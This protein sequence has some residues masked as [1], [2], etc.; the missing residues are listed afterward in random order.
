MQVALQRGTLEGL[1]V[2]GTPAMLRVKCPS[3]HIMAVKDKHIGR[4]VKCPQ[5][6][7]AMRVKP[8][9]EPDEDTTDEGRIWLCPAG[10]HFKVLPQHSGKAVKCPRCEQPVRIPE[11]PP[12]AIVADEQTL[13][14]ESSLTTPQDGTTNPYTANEEG[15]LHTAAKPVVARSPQEKL[16]PVL[17][18]LGSAVSALIGIAL[19]MGKSGTN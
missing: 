9:R 8:P 5:C 19:Y 13:D 14:I 18:L 6:F 15:V 7:I 3:G 1:V 11:F 16:W 12:T 2:P 10:H 4:K 17:L